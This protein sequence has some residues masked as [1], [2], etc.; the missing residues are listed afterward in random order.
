[1]GG[2]VILILLVYTPSFFIVGGRVSPAR[3]Y[4]K[5]AP[6]TTFAFSSASSNATIPLTLGPV[7]R[8][9][10]PEEV[11]AFTIPWNHHQHERDGHLP[12]LCGRLYR[13]GHGLKP[14]PAGPHDGGRNRSSVLGQVP[15]GSPDLV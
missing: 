4:K 7:T 13:R 14:E 2:I 12:G 1:M 11:S 8:L 9:G 5:V 10:I 15:Q 6:V 3:F